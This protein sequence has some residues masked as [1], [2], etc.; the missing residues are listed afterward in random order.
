MFRIEKKR[1]RVKV[2]KFRFVS[3]QFDCNGIELSKA[4][5]H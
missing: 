3:Q 2:L 1:E 5:L 4:L